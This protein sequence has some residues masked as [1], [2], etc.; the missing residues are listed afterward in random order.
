ML[1]ITIG[2]ECGDGCYCDKYKKCKYK[3]KWHKF[4][5]ISVKI[6]KFFEYRLHIKLP[7]LIYID[8]KWER[9]SGTD[10]C[11][12][13]KSRFYARPEEIEVLNENVV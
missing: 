10:K 11:P 4:H 12:F 7:H 5:N 9:L 13:H 6:H 1:H 8:Q 2:Y 3:S